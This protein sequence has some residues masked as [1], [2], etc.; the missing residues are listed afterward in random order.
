MIFS[1]DEV[2][3]SGRKPIKDINK[4]LNLLKEMIIHDAEYEYCIVK[5]KKGLGR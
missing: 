2:R 5:V 4:G 1:I 3:I